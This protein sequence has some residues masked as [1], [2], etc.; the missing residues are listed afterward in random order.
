MTKNAARKVN[1][2]DQGAKL[3]AVETMDEADRLEASGE[4]WDQVVAAAMHAR[5]DLTRGADPADVL[6][7][8]VTATLARLERDESR[9]AEAVREIAVVLLAGLAMVESD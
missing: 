5:H 8:L 4:P 1:G 6:G 7:R 2:N 3:A 9:A